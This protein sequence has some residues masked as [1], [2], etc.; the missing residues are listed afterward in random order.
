MFFYLE[1]NFPDV[2]FPYIRTKA[3]KVII[4]MF[5][6]NFVYCVPSSYLSSKQQFS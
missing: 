1:A 5:T 3:D 4:L 6:S 2:D